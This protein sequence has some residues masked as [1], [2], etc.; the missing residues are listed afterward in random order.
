MFNDR[1]PPTRSEWIVVEVENPIWIIRIMTKKY[2]WLNHRAGGS[3]V[4]EGLEFEPTILEKPIDFSTNTDVIR[5]NVATA[6]N[7]QITKSKV[8]SLHRRVVATLERL[9]MLSTQRTIDESL[10]SVLVEQEMCV[11]AC[12]PTDPRGDALL[13]VMY[14][15]CRRLCQNWTIVLGISCSYRLLGGWLPRRALH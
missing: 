7:K 15:N 11:A 9:L 1:M 6:F 12:L 14:G 3:I 13:D 4:A 2:R 10:C 5:I 8:V